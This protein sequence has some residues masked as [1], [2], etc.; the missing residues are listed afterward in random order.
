MEEEEEKEGSFRGTVEEGSVE[1]ENAL[2]E[3]EDILNLDLDTLA[4]TLEKHNQGLK[5]NMID[6]FTEQKEKLK[7]KAT[8]E[9]SLMGT[10][11]GCAMAAKQE[12]IRILEEQLVSSKEQIKCLTGRVSCCACVSTN[13]CGIV[14]HSRTVDRRTH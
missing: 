2:P 14:E 3:L 6:F 7:N 1:N 8:A 12:E 13:I 10:K 9:L 5:T 4:Y 11:H